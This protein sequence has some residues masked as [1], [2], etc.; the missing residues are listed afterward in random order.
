MELVI[1]CFP[2]LNVR[3]IINHIISNII[4]VIPELKLKSGHM[5]EY[6][7]CVVGY[8]TI[9]PSP[10]GGYDYECNG[11]RWWKLFI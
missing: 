5:Y 4:H 1:F 8:S 6:V 11:R 9:E 10:C 7:I 2:L 3:K